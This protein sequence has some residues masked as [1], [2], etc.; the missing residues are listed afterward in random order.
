MT[1]IVQSLLMSVGSLW[2]DKLTN[3]NVDGSFGQSTTFTVS[4]KCTVTSIKLYLKKGGSPTGNI[5][6]QLSQQ[7]APTTF[8][9][10]ASFDAAALT[11]SYVETDIT[12][13]YS[14]ALYPKV[15][16]TFALVPDAGASLSTSNY[17]VVQGTYA[18]YFK[19]E[20]KSD[21][22]TWSSLM[23]DRMCFK[24][25]GTVLSDGEEVIGE[26]LFD[27][28][29]VPRA[30][31]TAVNVDRVHPTANNT[32]H[33][34]AAC[35]TFTTPNYVT[36]LKY[37]SFQLS[38]TTL[39]LSGTSYKIKIY[40]VQGTVNV[41]SIPSGVPIAESDAKTPT[42]TGDWCTSFFAFSGANKI[43]LAANHVYA[44]TIEGISG[45]DDTHGLTVLGE[46]T[47]NYSGG[48]LARYFNSV[49]G[50]V[51]GANV[52]FGL[53]VNTYSAL[54]VTTSGTGTATIDLTDA[55]YLTNTALTAHAT[56]QTHHNISAWTVNGVNSGSGNTFNFNILADTTLDAVVAEDTK[57]TLTIIQVFDDGNVVTPTSG[58]QYYAD[59]LVSLAATNTATKVFY[60]WKIAAS[61]YYTN[62]KTLYLS[63]NTTVYSV[64]TAK[65]SGVTVGTATF[66]TAMAEAVK[67]TVTTDTNTY[68]SVVMNGC[69]YQRAFY[70]NGVWFLFYNKLETPAHQGFGSEGNGVYYATSTDGL[71]WTNETCLFHSDLA[72]TIE[73]IAPYVA[74]NDPFAY[75]V[76]CHA[77]I[78]AGNK[79][80][81][82]IFNT[83]RVN[84]D[85]S[86]TFGTW[87]TVASGTEGVSVVNHPRIILDKLSIPWITWTRYTPGITNFSGYAQSYIDHST[88]R[89]TWVSAG[90]V[91]PYL[92]A[93]SPTGEG[94]D[95]E[96]VSTPMCVLSDN[97]VMAVTTADD[98][99][100]N[101]GYGKGAAFRFNS[102][103]LINTFDLGL[104]KWI[105]SF[106][107]N[108]TVTPNDR[109]FFITGAY[110]I[111]NYLLD[112]TITSTWGQT[113]LEISKT[114]VV[115]YT[116][117]SGD[118]YGFQIAYDKDF[119]LL[120]LLGANAPN[121]NWSANDIADVSLWLY[122]L[123]ANLLSSPY[124]FLSDVMQYGDFQEYIES[125]SL[126]GLAG[127]GHKC[128]FTISDKTNVPKPLNYYSAVVD[129]FTLFGEVR[130]PRKTLGICDGVISTLETNWE[131]NGYFW[132]DKAMWTRGMFESNTK[133]RQIIAEME[134]NL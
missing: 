1:E 71:T 85:N 48:N 130:Q 64:F 28:S 36:Q 65:P 22:S 100:R 109:V 6:F 133:L 92:I 14:G 38:L 33:R 74:F 102:V 3:N 57:Y 31:N 117:V 118:P 114:A 9:A 68:N 37:A 43:D 66:P 30:I 15:A 8:L 104:N 63:A 50:A 75:F 126:N 116:R 94:W 87:Q 134:Q 91:F 124:L 99:I 132:S 47:D 111:Y 115:N 81:S 55:T 26:S 131:D 78:V 76:M 70:A 80:F 13:S 32:P 86:L 72:S 62:P 21:A 73:Y 101:Y 106:E 77:E 24:L 93:Q 4:N 52:Y 83:A 39:S 113:L 53:I 127:N 49:W 45:L 96:G 23:N 27:G 103:E 29:N 67:A 129:Y 42:V 105:Y 19:A 18:N 123:N 46:T 5:N 61:N 11:T 60:K 122:D 16:Y 95:M 44:V 89:E 90:N 58:N 35:Q 120:Y 10:T 128:L 110:P 79:V 88:N 17:V 41:D 59:E 98:S 112:N 7:S 125:A 56:P 97:T 40:E 2:D 12:F 82:I 107:T 121:T 34:S 119:N 25:Y 108:L 51:G 20:R 54:T 84:A 69:S